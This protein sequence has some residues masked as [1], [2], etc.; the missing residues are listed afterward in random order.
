MN[1]C[2]LTTEFPSPEKPEGGLGNYTNNISQELIKRGNNIT[3]IALGR[4]SKVQDFDSIRIRFIKR[5]RI[6]WRIKKLCNKFKNFSL[7]ENLIDSVKIKKVVYEEN[8]NNKFDLIQTP[9]F[10]FPG[11]ALINDKEIPVVCRCSSCSPLLR[12]AN[13]LP[14]TFSEY[15]YDWFEVRQVLKSSSSF[16]PSK[17]IAKMYQKI[18]GLKPLVIRSPI[19]LKNFDEDYSIFNNLVHKK[20]YLLFFGRLN[21]VKGVDIFIDSLPRILKKYQ[22]LSV[23]FIGENDLL[24][25]GHNSLDLMKEKLSNYISEKRVVYSPSIPKNQLFPIIKNSMGVVIPSRVDN[26]PNSCLEAFPLGIPVIGSNESSL[27]EIVTDGQTGF[28]FENGSSDDLQN[29]IDKLI[30]L[31]PDQRKE[32]NNN[33]KYDVQSF[34]EEDRVASLE[35]YYHTVINNFQ[36]SKG[37]I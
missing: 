2:F 10:N 22:D 1:I 21:L 20:D 18:Y 32:F 19:R 31:N 12:S 24:T 13:G 36:T 7:F 29:A 8:S 15:I 26:Y 25:D 6:N 37:S 34:L 17:F 35:N 16:T 9:N 27:E 28:L 4:K 3:I 30:N 11:N 5:S 23:L 14:T 33:I